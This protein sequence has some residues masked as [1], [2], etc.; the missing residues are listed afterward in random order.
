MDLYDSWTTDDSLLHN[1]PCNFRSNTC[2]DLHIISFSYIL[3]ALDGKPTT[4]RLSTRLNVKT[5]SYND[6][7]HATS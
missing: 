6:F 1:F 2:G 7:D 4:G 5:G 3:R